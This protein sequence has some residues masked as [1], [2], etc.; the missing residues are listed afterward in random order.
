MALSDPQK[1]TARRVG[2]YDRLWFGKSITSNH[3]VSPHQSF[4]N[5][6]ATADAPEHD[7]GAFPWQ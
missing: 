7:A 5:A 4:A 6:V 1:C 2:S 3:A